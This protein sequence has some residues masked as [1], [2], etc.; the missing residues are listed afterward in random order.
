MVE[1][2]RTPF[3]DFVHLLSRSNTVR[4]MSNKIDAL[5]TMIE[6]ERPTYERWLRSRETVMATIAHSF[7][8]LMCTPRWGKLYL[9]GTPGS[10]AT[11]A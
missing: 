7:R 4:R 6:H 9:I 3:L 5:A 11:A 1:P 10:P 2:W 8:L